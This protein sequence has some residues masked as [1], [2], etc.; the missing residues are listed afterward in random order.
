MAE[1]N[2]R[3][4]AKAREAGISPA[5]NSALAYALHRN[6]AGLR[7]I[8]LSWAGSLRRKGG[9]CNSALVRRAE[10]PPAPG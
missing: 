7:A 9:I 8:R 5:R 3:P 1:G 4:T 10:V 2:I 6:L